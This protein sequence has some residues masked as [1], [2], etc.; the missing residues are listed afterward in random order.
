[1]YGCESW[2]IKKA[3][4]WRI[5]AFELWC[6][7]RLLRVPWT[8]RRSNQSILKIS[9]GC[10]LEGLMLKLKLQYFGHW[11]EELTHLKKPWCWERLRA[12]GE[13][14]D[15]GWDG[16]MASLTQWTWVWVNSG[17]WQWTGRP[18]V[19]QFMGSQRV[20]HNWATELNWI[21]L[22]NVKNKL[23]LVKFMACSWLCLM[24]SQYKVW[25]TCEKTEIFTGY[26]FHTFVP[27]SWMWIKKPVW[28]WYVH[29]AVFK[30]DN[31][32]GPTVQHRELCSMLGSSLNESGVAG[33]MDIG[34]WMAESR[35]CPPET[36]TTL[37]ISYTPIQNKKLK[38]KKMRQ[39]PSWLFF[40][41]LER[42]LLNVWDKQKLPAR[43]LRASWRLAE[44]GPELRGLGSQKAK[45]W[46]ARAGLGMAAWGLPVQVCQENSLR[47]PNPR[48]NSFQPSQWPSWWDSLRPWRR[49]EYGDVETNFRTRAEPS[50][51][52]RFT[53]WCQ[54]HCK[55]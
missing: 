41:L 53:S 55:F 33:R 19:L 47:C 25:K 15:R 40:V 48:R 30:M 3:E 32:Q 49:P 28:D 36:I 9:P 12:G 46:Q 6:R 13:G 21:D 42:W 54:W 50:W 26:P 44:M 16:W 52:M 29:S 35:C 23:L 43:R 51:S 7:R 22:D 10:S 45:G 2:T 4:S 11:C 34:I 14:V 8:A 37:S 1:M 27:L 17:S 24:H 38:Q 31:H 5:D 20:R 18:G 39:Q